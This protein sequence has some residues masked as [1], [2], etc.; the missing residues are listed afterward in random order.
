PY[1]TL[2]RSVGV[3]HHLADPLAGWRALL[4]LMKPGA[5]M[6]IGLYSEIAR[7]DVVEAR[8]FIASRGFTPTA[9]GIRACRQEIMRGGE[10]LRWAGLTNVSDFFSMSGCRDMIFNAMEHRFTLPRIKAFL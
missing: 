2:F 6:C 10:R 7:R 3:L 5:R 8:A 9:D 4:P 1:T